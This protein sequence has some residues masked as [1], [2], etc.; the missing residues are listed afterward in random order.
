MNKP[1]QKQTLKTFN[2]WIAALKK[3]DHKRFNCTL[4]WFTAASG[5]VSSRPFINGNPLCHKAFEATVHAIQERNVTNK[6]PCGLCPVSEWRVD[7]PYHEGECINNIIFQSIGNG[8]R[9]NI[10]RKEMNNLLTKYR[11]FINESI[12]ADIKNK[13]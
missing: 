11:R 8:L 1:K 13:K 10:T 4:S 6:H 9:D 3:L 5:H 7:K 12:K 2:A